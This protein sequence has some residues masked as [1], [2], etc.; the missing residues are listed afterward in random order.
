MLYAST[1][2]EVLLAP[3]GSSRAAK[4][5]ETLKEA[6][7]KAAARKL[8]AEKKKK[9]K[10]KSKAKSK[11]KE[12]PAANPKRPAEDTEQFAPTMVDALGCARV[13]MFGDDALNA[14][15]YTLEKANPKQHRSGVI[16]KCLDMV[17]LFAF[18]GNLSAA[19]FPHNTVWTKAGQTIKTFLNRAHDPDLPDKDMAKACSQQTACSGASKPDG[20]QEQERDENDDAAAAVKQLVSI[21]KNTNEKLFTGFVEANFS[22]FTAGRHHRKRK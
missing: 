15:N 6:R 14:I 8:D 4:L 20:G 22:E 17:C 5:P 13:T 18:E 1:K 9:A 19:G 21:L 16:S 2:V 7:E 10:S 3:M 12:T 11:P